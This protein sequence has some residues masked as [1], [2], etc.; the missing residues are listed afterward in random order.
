MKSR[1]KKSRK[2][3]LFPLNPPFAAPSM[4]SL[5]MD[6]RLA[7]DRPKPWKV[8]YQIMGKKSNEVAFLF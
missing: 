4:P 3:P 6:F 5:L 7:P 2:Q 1:R 8:F